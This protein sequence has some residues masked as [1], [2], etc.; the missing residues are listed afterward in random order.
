MRKI[1]FVLL[2]LS[3]SAF[4]RNSRIMTYNVHNGKGL[5]NVTD[6]AR[7][8]CLIAEI[9]PEVVAIQEVDSMTRRS[10]NR[11]VLDS[12]AKAAGMVPTFAPAIDYN[13][14]RYGIG[15]LS[16]EKPLKSYSIPMPGREEER[17][18][19]VCEFKDYVFA[20][21]HMS[22]TEE[23][24]DASVKL[25]KEEA[26][27]WK[28]PFILAGDWNSWPDSNVVKGLSE[29]MTILTDMSAFTFPADTPNETIDYIAIKGKKVKARP[30][31]H[32]GK[33]ESDHLPVSVDIKW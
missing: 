21:I 17:R 16:K 31:V 15:I 22:L 33:L 9:D 12:I 19:L 24:R 25:I 13:G 4:G 14:G 30:T 18:L 8:G 5:D 26:D 29:F 28:K 6:Y 3:I 32:T 2:V 27:K 11:V 1:I 7:I 23:D 20:C 10:Q